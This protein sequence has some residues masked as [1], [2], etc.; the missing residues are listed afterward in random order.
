M[1]DSPAIHIIKQRFTKA[2]LVLPPIPADLAPQL[3]KRSDWCFSTKPLERSPYGFEDFVQEG[4]QADVPDSLI[5]AHAGHGANSY[6]LS[7]YL[8]WKS[9]RLFLQVAW[10]GLYV[11]EDWARRQVNECFSL[12]DSLVA[13][14]DRAATAGLFQSGDRLVVA[15]SSF[16]GGFWCR[17]G[18]EPLSGRIRLTQ[19][20][21]VQGLL[22]AALEWLAQSD[23]QHRLPF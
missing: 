13:A 21:S 20:G 14:V 2:G 22:K 12:A 23:P 10:G 5:L 19:D 17:P 16:Y 11:E 4:S 18:E 15:V 6:A 9:L 7:Y 8:I 3:M 1:T